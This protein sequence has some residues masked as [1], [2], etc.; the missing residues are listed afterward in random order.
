M[1]DLMIGHFVHLPPRRIQKIEV[2]GIPFE[3]TS[4]WLTGEFATVA[5]KFKTEFALHQTFGQIFFRVL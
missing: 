2:A 3:L 5:T 1:R 4:F